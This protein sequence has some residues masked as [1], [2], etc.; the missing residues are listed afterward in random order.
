MNQINNIDNNIN[1]KIILD[2]GNII[3]AFNN[4]RMDNLDYR[5]YKYSKHELN[6]FLNEYIK[7]HTG[8]FKYNNVSKNNIIHFE[9]YYNFLLDI[10]LNHDVKEQQKIS[11]IHKTFIL[12]NLSRLKNGIKMLEKYVE[13]KLFDNAFPTVVMM[14]ELASIST[15]PSFIF[16][17][18]KLKLD[19]FEKDN[20]QI[21][22]ESFKNSDD[23]IYKWY[24]E[25]F[26]KE[27]K[28]DVINDINNI[29]FILYKILSG[30]IIEKYTLRKLK[31]ISNYIDLSKYFDIILNNLIGYKKLNE[32]FYISLF[33]HNYKLEIKYQT[34]I[35]FFINIFK[36]NYSNEFYKTIYDMLKSQIE[37]VSFAILFIMYFECSNNIFPIDILSNEYNFFKSTRDNLLDNSIKNNKIIKDKQDSYECIILDEFSRVCLSKNILMYYPSNYGINNNSK[38]NT[39]LEFMDYECKCN[40]KCFNVIIKFFIRNKIFDN[41]NK[42]SF[43]PPIFVLFSN[44]YINFNNFKY[45]NYNYL[46]QLYN[47]IKIRYFLNNIIKIKKNKI[48]LQNKLKLSSMIN[49]FNK[50]KS[51]NLLLEGSIK[52]QHENQEYNSIPP[53]YFIPSNSKNIINCYITDKADGLLLNILPKDIYPKWNNNFIVKAEFIEDLNLYLVYDINIPNMLFEERYEYLR[54]KH[55]ITKE[56]NNYFIDSI[57]TLKI[58][59]QNE[60]ILL[61]NF[62]NSH[63]ENV[64]KWY[65]K[66]YYKF[67]P[68]INNTNN[69]FFRNL[70]N[71][72]YIKSKSDIVDFINKG[73]Y[74]CDGLIIKSLN[75]KIEMKIKPKNLMTI[76][77]LY[78]GEKWIDDSKNV[79]NNVICDIIPLKNKVYRCYPLD[80]KYEKCI[81]K[82]IRYD[83]KIPNKTNIIKNIINIYKTDWSNY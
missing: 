24:L 4:E 41:L 38:F 53:Q 49:E 39:F 57:K 8:F 56:I 10:L 64:I 68:S 17:I 61:N 55:P 79:Y 18:K 23:R 71:E 7:I 77:L 83:K 72:F 16:W 26:K 70:T 65:P 3:D 27:N 19:I 73:L 54:K 21:F 76:D 82:E 36:F 14:I 67:I 75:S 69:N 43:Y 78:D 59:L 5:N 35:P 25:K 46:K 63:D 60:R 80:D 47:F 22:F 50:I 45:Y 42:I 11:S 29:K 74:N 37:R 30:N 81:V 31:D 1:N 62:I 52:Q 44:I 12:F 20:L 51:N 2:I 6:V 34:H 40:K 66:A 9:S 32:N 48:I 15:F 28:L 13:T 33:K 58:H